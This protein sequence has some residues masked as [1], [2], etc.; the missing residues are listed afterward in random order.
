MS[1]VTNQMFLMQN[2]A[3][4][5]DLNFQIQNTHQA[6]MGLA[7][8]AGMMGAAAAGNPFSPAFGAQL[9]AIQAADKAIMLSNANAQVQTEALYA[10]QEQLQRMMKADFERRQR[11]AQNGWIA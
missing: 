1:W 5:S 4:L 11:W 3:R 7:N 9:G 6:Q 10:W 2:A 8:T